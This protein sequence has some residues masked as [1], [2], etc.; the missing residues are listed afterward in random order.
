MTKEVK[1]AR[2]VKRI[3]FYTLQFNL[4]FAMLYLIA[5][6]FGES[7]ISFVNWMALCEVVLVL[8]ILPYLMYAESR[9]LRP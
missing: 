9:K 2:W 3:A 1:M 6:L 8:V 7:D 4:L 5:S